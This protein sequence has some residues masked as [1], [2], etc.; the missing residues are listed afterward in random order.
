RASL[1]RWLGSADTLSPLRER[2]FFEVAS[3]G[4]V[5]LR[6]FIRGQQT[7][8]AAEAAAA[9]REITEALASTAPSLRLSA[10]VSRLPEDERRQ[11]A[12]EL[13]GGDL[14]PDAV[15]VAAP[16]PETPSGPRDE[17]MDRF[18]DAVP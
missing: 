8:G 7:L 17:A 10:A 15:I 9:L 18:R 4:R 11:L 13:A 2:L 6:S 12:A 1:E 3:D 14:Q 16:A 5:L